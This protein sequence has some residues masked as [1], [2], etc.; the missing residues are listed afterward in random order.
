[1]QVALDK[2]QRDDWFGSHF[3]VIMTTLSATALIG[4]LIWEWYHK[5]PIIDLHLFK[6]RSFAI[7]N[8]LMFMV[9]FALMSSTVLLPLFVKRSWAIQPSRLVLR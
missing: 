5:D 1:M 9:G 4:V 7:G 2:G 6:D 3:I 8:L